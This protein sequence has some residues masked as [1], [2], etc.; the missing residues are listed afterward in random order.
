MQSGHQ[1]IDYCPTRLSGGLKRKEL[2]LAIKYAVAAVIVG[3]L[4]LAGL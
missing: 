3:G 2:A 4:F 1:R